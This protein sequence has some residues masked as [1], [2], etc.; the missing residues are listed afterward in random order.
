MAKTTPR[1]TSSKVSTLA[2]GVLA[3]RVKPTPAQVKTL[4]ATAL[5]QDQT[6]GQK[7]K[8]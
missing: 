2:S 8:R 6:K 1:P 5:S 4:A 7:P 3:G